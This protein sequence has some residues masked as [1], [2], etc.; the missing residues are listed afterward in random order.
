MLRLVAALVAFAAPCA[1]HD[2]TEL[3]IA[4]FVRSSEDYVEVNLQDTVAGRNIICAI[5]DEAGTLL[6][7]EDTYTDNLA[8]RVLIRWDGEAPAAARCVFND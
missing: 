5:Y 8:T 2:F 1:A 3:K 7:S 4:S 6:T